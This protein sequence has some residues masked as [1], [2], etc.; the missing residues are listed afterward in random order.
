MT[1]ACDLWAHE[2]MNII[3]SEN[4]VLYM[5]KWNEIGF[6]IFS[7]LYFVHKRSSLNYS[8]IFIKWP[9]WLKLIYSYMT[10]SPF[11]YVGGDPMPGGTMCTKNMI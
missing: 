2:H 10:P 1:L 4:R 11:G 8:I 3:L 9:A 5:Y 6:E 7:F